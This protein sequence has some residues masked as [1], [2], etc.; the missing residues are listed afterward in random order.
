MLRPR[1][2][3]LVPNLMVWSKEHKG[4]LRTKVKGILDR[5]VRRFGAPLIE[6]LVG[7]ADRKLVVNIRKERERKKRK[8]KE[9]AENDDEDDGTG[10]AAGFSNEFDRAVY[11]S[12]VS[13]D[14]DSDSEVEVQQKKGGKRGG[15][16]GEQYIRELSPESNP[17]DL[18]A[19]D[20]LASIS[21]TKPSL[22][23][24]DNGV[25]K[26]KKRHGAKVDVDGKLILREG[27]D[28][29]NDPNDYEMTGGVEDTG[30]SGINAYLD[31]V[32]GPSAVR[33]GQKGR[34]KFG[35]KDNDGMDIDDDDDDNNDSNNTKTKAG[36]GGIAAGRRGLGMPK[37]HGASTAANKTK[38]RIEK[39]RM[40]GSGA[41]RGSGRGGFVAR[42]RGRGGRR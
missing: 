25:G 37:S 10:K 28:H 15:S 13:S 21:T 42:S 38:G 5:L 40:S 1:L 16:K 8:K 11:G 24:L 39:R 23:F 31:A 22:R 6:G 17:L 34:L 27:V 33:R 2:N 32:S 20:A 35:K 3:S 12:D 36:G 7:E 19:P 9:G 29:D 30:S 14:E 18:L 41:G 26:N 4:R